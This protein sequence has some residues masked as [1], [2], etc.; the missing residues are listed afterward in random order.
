MTQAVG[1]AAIFALFGLP[2]VPAQA[3]SKKK[4][5]SE[6][7]SVPEVPGDE[8]FGF[9]SPADVGNAGELGLANELDGRLGKRGGRYGGYNSKSE[10]GYTFAE[11]WWIGASPFGAWN[12]VR[13]VS[14]L[15]DISTNAFDGL[16][17]ELQYRLLRR[18][19]GNPFAI[20][21]AVEPR[22]ARIDSRL[23][24]RSDAYYADFKFLIDAVLIPDRIFWAANVYF[25]PQRAQ[26]I[27]ER[28]IWL[29]SSSTFLSTAV[30]FQL[31]PSVFVGA[32][33]RHL[34]SYNGASL[35]ERVGYAVYVGPTMAWKITDK[36][37]F[38]A[39]W[40]PQVS[41]RSAANPGLR[42]DL[43]NFERTQFR[44]KL[45]VQLN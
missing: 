45:S 29:N 36:I 41:G 44:V 28:G 19:V 13:D 43:D 30:T 38:N 20:S 26:D 39:T 6:S 3:A 2:V 34:A 7:H 15:A 11:D 27:I 31:S 12:N 8:I 4:A 14:G 42:Y 18:S 9:T 35:N 25:S 23:G 22:W 32:E 17:F 1:V 37:V 16:S 10:L 21:L 5:L 24:L 40:Q 33:V